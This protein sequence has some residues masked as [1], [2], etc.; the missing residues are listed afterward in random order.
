MFYSS[1]KSLSEAGDKELY[2]QVIDPKNNVLGANEQI[3]FDEQVLNYSL[4]SK[5]NYEKELR[6]LRICRT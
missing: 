6:Y 1:K 3:T 4:I 2:V 5:F